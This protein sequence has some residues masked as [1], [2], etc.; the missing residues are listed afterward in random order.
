MQAATD[1]IRSQIRTMDFMTRSSELIIDRLVA[2]SEYWPE[3]S[4]YFWIQHE[5]VQPLWFWRRALCTGV[6]AA[7]PSPYKTIEYWESQLED[8]VYWWLESFRLMILQVD[9]LKRTGVDLDRWEETWL[10]ALDGDLNIQVF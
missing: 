10:R 2:A 3:N 9:S 6:W 4:R 5:S 7:G 8:D 1:I